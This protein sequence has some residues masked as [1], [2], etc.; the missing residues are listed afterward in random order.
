M[1]ISHAEL[2]R[3]LPRLLSGREWRHDGGSIR[4]DHGPRRLSIRYGPQRER[5][6]AALRLPV[7]EISFVFDGYGEAEAGNF[8]AHFD[9]T[10]RR[11]GG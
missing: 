7:T 2:F 10:Y 3:L 1:G 4:V 8:M 9:R 5:R 6:I 11:G